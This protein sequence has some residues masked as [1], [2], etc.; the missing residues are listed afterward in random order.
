MN[1]A[2]E[3]SHQ[4]TL[5]WGRSMLELPVLAMTT[6]FLV[7]SGGGDFCVY[8]VSQHAFRI[9]RVNSHVI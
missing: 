8:V 6:E 4:Q 5:E 1:I 2:G 7:S 9:H 3:K